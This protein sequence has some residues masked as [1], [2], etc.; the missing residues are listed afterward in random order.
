MPTVADT[1]K[2]LSENPLSP[3]DLR[4]SLVFSDRFYAHEAT[5][6]MLDQPLITLSM[7]LYSPSS[8]TRRPRRLSIETLERRALLSADTS[9]S[10]LLPES[11][12][13]PDFVATSVGMPASMMTDGAMME[14]NESGSAAMNH[15]PTFQNF[16][17]LTPLS[18]G[19]LRHSA[20]GGNWSELFG[21]AGPNDIIEVRHQVFLDVSV[22][23]HTIVVADGG[24]LE[25][26]DDK[27]LSLRVVN[28]QVLAGGQL[29][30]GTEQSPVQGEIQIIFKDAPIDPAR[31]PGQYGNGLVVAGVVQMHGRTLD[32][33]FVTLANEATAGSQQLTLDG[34]TSGWQSGD[35]LLLPDSRQIFY[36]DSVSSKLDHYEMA[37]LASV[38]S[39]GVSLDSPLAYDHLGARDADGNLVFTPHV[40]N[41]TRNITLRSENP[42]GTRGHTLYT[43][44]AD[45][46]IRYVN[47][48]DLGRT[49]N[50]LL[51]DTVF[52]ADGNATHIGT[53]QQARYA[54]HMHHLIGPEAGQG[55]GY[56]FTLMGNSVVNTSNAGQQKWGLVVH[57]S[58][59]GLI[60]SN[61]VYNYSGAGII[62]ED[63]S[64]VFNMFSN[65]F[66]SRIDGTRDRGKFT[67]GREGS[68]FWLNSPYNSLVGNVVSGAEKSGY[69]IYGSSSSGKAPVAIPAFQGANPHSS[70]HVMMAPESMSVLQFDNNE[71]YASHMG[72]EIWYLG[73][74]NYFDPTTR[75]L[76]ESHFNDLHLW[77]IDHTAVFG[78]QAN[79]LTIRD[80]VVIGDQSLMT[81]YNKPIGIY[82]RRV[83]DFTSQNSII[84]NMRTGISVAERTGR[85]GKNVSLYEVSPFL[86]EGGLLRNSINIEIRTPA[87]D[88]PSN[89]PPRYTVIRDV[90][91][92]G[93]DGSAVPVNNIVMRYDGGRVAWVVQSDVIEVEGYGGESGNDFRLY[94]NEQ[95]PDF[96]VPETGSIYSA[97]VSPVGAPV[98]GL[99]N[100]EAWKTYGIAVGGEVAPGDAM[101]SERLSVSGVVGLAFPLLQHLAPPAITA[102]D[103]DSGAAGDFVTN[104]GKLVLSGVARPAMPV[105]LYQDDVVVGSTVASSQGKWQFDNRDVQLVGGSYEFAVTSPI[106]GSNGARSESVVVKVFTTPPSLEGGSYAT[107]EGMEVNSVVGTIAV[108]DPDRDDSVTLQI[109]SGNAGG[110]FK[111]DSVSGRLSIAKDLGK[112][113]NR[114]IHELGILA[115][116][117]AGLISRATVQIAITA[118]PAGPWVTELHY[119]QFA[120]LS[121]AEIMFLT[122][123]QLSTI[124]SA[125]SF[126]NIP[127][128]SRSALTSDQVRGLNLQLTGMISGLDEQQILQ[129][130]DSQ[131][132][133]IGGGGY[134][135]LDYAQLPPSKITLLTTQQLAKI[136]SKTGFLRIPEASRAALTPNQVRAINLAPGGMITGFTSSQI[137]ELS[138]DQLHTLG[139][140]MYG[141]L[142][143][144]YLPASRIVQL[145]SSQVG[146]I[147]SSYGFHRISSNARAAFTESQVRALDL[148]SAGMIGGL[149][150]AQ[151]EM[152][153]VRQIQTIG[154]ADFQYL[155][156]GQIKHLTHDQLRLIS[157]RWHWDRISSQS[158][159]SLA[160]EGVFWENG[161]LVIS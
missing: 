52:D 55:N 86:V 113:T 13:D 139:N 158:K 95:R 69:A 151:I 85:L 29:K 136:P 12:F 81:Y 152:L 38:S 80:L 155:P 40:A 154:L 71:S 70:D 100:A 97:P 116:D 101:S 145:T 130:S 22:D 89:R 88:A 78:E 66:V 51:D 27:D 26:A 118:R 121:P 131:V 148:S 161:E 138:V 125:D 3:L 45:V 103:P 141:Y 33:T 10:P 15:D 94:Y 122:P 53:N 54:F 120:E 41:L 21:I 4:G 133:E 156:P 128:E 107:N 24:S 91:Y 82:L 127:V 153:T 61:I 143:F 2:I 105:T 16:A 36:T 63:G 65:N 96:I 44:R 8:R 150:A 111:L 137:L 104:D 159:A 14:H 5:S 30:I 140:G 25:F 19:Q 47:F 123:E 108:R 135:Y 58:H 75:P 146:L 84:E 35:T 93:N 114:G 98:A 157:S 32:S 7:K 17:T 23:V 43:G 37:S 129:L 18:D 106:P 72:V 149:T 57:A 90:R 142:D 73:Y 160:D 76:A 124:P 77:H 110:L 109:E 87:E 112:A 144:S 79:K 62:T 99:T 134:G 6:F 28:L 50:A 1:V 102:I 68:G 9:F 64:E 48:L 83:S 56:Q 49:T 115:T 147:P 34:D 67:D 74:R 60:D 20:S 31:D 119:P 132:R 46:D 92:D 11:S 42:S 126:L 117:R 39:A 59:Y